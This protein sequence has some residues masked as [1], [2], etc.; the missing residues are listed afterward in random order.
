ME[1]DRIESK[2]NN[3]KD[4]EKSSYSPVHFSFSGIHLFAVNGLFAVH[5]LRHVRIMDYLRVSAGNVFLP[6]P[7]SIYSI[8]AIWRIALA[9]NSN[10]PDR[11]LLLRVFRMPD[12]ILYFSP[13]FSFS[14][15]Y[16]FDS[17][18]VPS[19]RILKFV[20]NYFFLFLF[21]KNTR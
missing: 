12:R 7:P 5:F 10:L 6:P 9:E 16:Y 19:S 2:W 15:F 13:L 18:E 3:L 20:S 8:T 17:T 4:L 21:R 11:P 14:Y 1:G